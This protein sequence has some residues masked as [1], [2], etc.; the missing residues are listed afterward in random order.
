MFG[1]E[2]TARIDAAAKLTIALATAALL[3]ANVTLRRAGRD[4]VL[5]RTRDALLGALGVA[6]AL[7]WWHFA[8]V[9]FARFV[10]EHDGFHYFIGAKYF[11]ELGYTRIYACS[12]QADLE[13]GVSP[14]WRA[15]NLETNVLEPIISTSDAVHPCKG[16]FTPARWSAFTAD[17]AWF[18]GRLPLADWQQI[19][20]DHGFNGSPVWMIAGSTLANAGSAAQIYRWL[21]LLDPLLDVALFAGVLLA[22]GRRTAC[23]AA[24]FFGTNGFDGYDW[25]AGSLLRQDW[26]VALGLG[27]AASRRNRPALAGALLGVA[28]LLRIFPAFVIAVLVLRTLAVAVRNRTLRIPRESLRF[29]AGCL[30]ALVVLLPLSVW[31]GGA[32]AWPSFVANSR[33]HLETPL[34]NQ[35]GLRPLVAFRTQTS[36]RVLEEPGAAD[37]MLRW[38]AAQHANFAERRGLFAAIAAIYLALLLRA[39]PRQ[40]QWAALALG[41][42][43]IPI[44]TQLTC[45]YQA[46]LF[47]LALLVAR[48]EPIGVALCLL[49][50]AT[51][52]LWFALP[53][54]DVKFVWMSGAELLVVLVVTW[55][56]G[57]N[58]APEP[59]AIL[60]SP[61]KASRPRAS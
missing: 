39:L 35:M 51:Q 14:G 26:L 54:S 48:S 55:I 12:L 2:M 49:A 25:T 22:F 61:A 32:H 5:R 19:R 46:A 29:A 58:G 52:W 53:Y 38:K 4:A 36:A 33:K 15:R 56:A 17:V 42:G 18:R 21:T 57:R 11:D 31:R 3:L 1:L 27:I 41:T 23:V 7:A 59:V 13:A 10:H 16:R 37:P 28:T 43:A 6:G 8:T 44:A 20:T 30:L 60:E 50:A 24:V 40:P 47:G 9:P 45:Y 34:L